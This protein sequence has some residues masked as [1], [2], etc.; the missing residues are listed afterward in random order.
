L[1]MKWSSIEERELTLAEAKRAGEVFITSSMRD[2]QGV[3]RWDDQVFSPMRP[4]TEAIA[5][6]FAELSQADLDP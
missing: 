2:I 6:T 3:E 5:A 4:I 1:I